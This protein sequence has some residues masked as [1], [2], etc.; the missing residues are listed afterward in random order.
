M[1][2]LV[3]GFGN[4]FFS[5]DGFGPQAVG[6]YRARWAEEGVRARDF[7]ISG[8]HLA[9]EMLEPYEVVVVVDAIARDEPPGTLF[10]VEPESSQAPAAPD[11]H[12]MDVRGVLALYERLKN[13]MEPSRN[14]KIVL[15]G[16]V[17]E[18]TAEGMTLS[19]AVAHALPAAAELIRDVVVRC[20]NLERNTTSTGAMP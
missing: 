17:P 13:E 14:P 5:D 7:G 20:G 16:C 3:A 8:M 1:K 10:V 4:V 15:V 12:A 11:A 19:P 9:L 18:T 2:A 6:L